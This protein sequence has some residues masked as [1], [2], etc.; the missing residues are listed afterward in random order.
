MPLGSDFKLDENPTRALK[1]GLK[2]KKNTEL[3]H[4]EQGII[5]K[6]S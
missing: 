1:L 4:Q 2:K 3:F 6:H 5:F